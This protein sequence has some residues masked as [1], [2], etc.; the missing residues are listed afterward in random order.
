MI[1]ISQLY[2]I[3]CAHSDV[4]TDTRVC[5]PGS[6]FFALRGDRFDGNSF[7]LKALEAGCAYAVVDDAAVAAQDA[8][9]LLVNDVLTT[10]QELARHHREQLDIPVIAI[11]GTNGKTTTKEL[12]RAVLSAKYNVLATEGNLNNH[13]GVPRTLLRI[14]PEHEIAIIEMGA[15]HPKEIE[16]LCAIAEPDCGLITN[17]GKAHLEGFGSLQGVIKTKSE[18]Y[19]WLREAEGTVFVNADN[20]L[21][22][23]LT[24]GIPTVVRYGY[25]NENYL[26]GDILRADPMLSFTFLGAEGTVGV[27][28]HLVGGYNLANC[29]AAAAVGRWF[30]VSDEAIRTALEGYEPSNK[31][32]QWIKTERNAV[33]LDAYNAN[34]TSMAAAIANVC[35]MEA[36]AKTLILGDMLELGAE[37]QVEHEAVVRTLQDDGFASVYLVGSAFSKVESPYPTFADTASLKAWLQEHPLADRT[38]LVKGSHGVALESVVEVL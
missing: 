8:R 10:L 28:T 35:T 11:T 25:D 15:S 26:S 33:I 20:D 37:S 22:L 14:R 23:P 1:T 13:I 21:L 2:D 18:L 38:I 6:L 34:P 17:V 12:T 9:C 4:T 31:R 27:K 5:R 16:Q 7:A 36:Q 30:G 32:S 3:Y 24:E 29:L 19:A